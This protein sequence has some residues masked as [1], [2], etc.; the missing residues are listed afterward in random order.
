MRNETTIPDPSSMRESTS[1][2]LSRAMQ[3]NLDPAMHMAQLRLAH[4]D[5]RTL[6]RMRDTSGPSGWTLRVRL[7][8]N[9]RAALPSSCTRKRARA[10]S[11]RKLFDSRGKR[12]YLSPLLEDES[13][14]GQEGGAML[15]MKLHNTMTTSATR[16]YDGYCVTGFTHARTT[17]RGLKRDEAAHLPELVLLLFTNRI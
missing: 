10:I 16:V 11:S 3:R 6:R 2:W 15:T 4:D 7:Y 5:R 13:L 14:A 1:R 17:C 12:G 9:R 8:V